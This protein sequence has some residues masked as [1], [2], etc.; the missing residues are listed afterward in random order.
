[1]NCADPL[2]EIVKLK[3]LSAKM[4]IFDKLYKVYE[5]NKNLSTKQ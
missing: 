5:V 3:S 4:L 1:M 2:S